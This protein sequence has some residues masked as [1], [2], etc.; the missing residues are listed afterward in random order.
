[1][2]N[3]WC[4]IVA[5]LMAIS[6]TLTETVV[7]CDFIFHPVD[8]NHPA[9]CQ[10]SLRYTVSSSWQ[11]FCLRRLPMTMSNI[12]WQAVAHFYATRTHCGQRT[13]AVQCRTATA[14]GGGYNA[15]SK[16]D[17]SSRGGGAGDADGQRPGL[18]QY[19]VPGLDRPVGAICGPRASGPAIVRSD[20]RV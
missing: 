16:L 3:E 15:L 11:V 1:M 10:T 13:S 2:A 6:A 12:V 4:A 7:R 20:Q 19:E 17:R 18:R 5:P 8:W 9:D 14:T